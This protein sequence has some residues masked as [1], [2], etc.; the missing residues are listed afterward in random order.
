M[1]T[2]YFDTPLRPVIYQPGLVR[3]GA[4]NCLAMFARNLFSN[5]ESKQE[6]LEFLMF[7]QSLSGGLGR[8]L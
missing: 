3:R 8:G 5:E 1:T 6:R 4:V 7:G 2:D